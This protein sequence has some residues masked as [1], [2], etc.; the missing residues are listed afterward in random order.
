MAIQSVKPIA[1]SLVTWSLRLLLCVPS[2]PL[3]LTL[4]FGDLWQFRRFWQSPL[5]RANPRQ[6]FAFPIP[7]MTRDHGDSN[8]CHP[9]S[10]AVGFCFPDSGDHG[11]FD[12]LAI[13]VIRVNQW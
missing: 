11:D 9:C 13:S 10:S 2:R 6:G 5:V 3:R 7:A 12:D 1:S 8:Q 4:L